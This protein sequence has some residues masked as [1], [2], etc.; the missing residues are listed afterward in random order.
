VGLSPPFL[1]PL[2]ESGSNE[3]DYP[4]GLPWC[5]KLGLDLGRRQAGGFGQADSGEWIWAGRFRQMISRTLD[6]GR[7]GGGRF[8]DGANEIFFYRSD[9]NY[10]TAK[11]PKLP[12]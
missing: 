3:L 8:W 9:E 11:P 4:Q 1:V 2:P 5:R 10:K 7:I 12:M 6:P